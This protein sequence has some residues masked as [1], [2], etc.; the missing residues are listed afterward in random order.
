MTHKDNIRKAISSV[1]PADGLAAVFRGGGQPT[2]EQRQHVQTVASEDALSEYLASP[3][4]QADVA[5]NRGDL[6]FQY[7]QAVQLQKAVI[8]AMLGSTTTQRTG[9]ASEVLNA[10][11]GRGWEIVSA[12]HVFVSEG[13]QS[14][15]KFMSSGQN[16]A[17]KG[18]TVGYY[19]FRRSEDNR[20]DRDFSELPTG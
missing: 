10:V 12:S 4:G 6:V 14:R 3:V 8:V 17:T 18:H 11:A 5:F 16:V 9:D 20:R 1:S 13:H 15:D 2:A 19:V 7:E